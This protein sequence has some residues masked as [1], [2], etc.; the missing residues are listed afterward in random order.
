MTDATYLAGTAGAAG[1]APEVTGLASRG[2][3]L[4]AGAFLLYTFIGTRPFS[5]TSVAG[6]TD[7]NILDRVAVIGMV[8]LALKLLW[9]QRG[10]ALTCLGHNLP[11]FGLVGFAC[12]SITWSDYPD[13]TLRRGMLLAF[14]TV[15]AMA[16]AV[17]VS[18]L[19]RFHTF[20]FV[21]MTGVVLFNL[22]GTV[23]MPSMSIT[24]IGVKG[25]YTQKNV[26]GIV[27]MITAILGVSWIIGADDRKGVIRALVALAPTLLFL[28]LT[29]SKTSINMTVAGIGLLTY[30]ALAEK[31]GRTFILATGMVG[32]LMLAAG[33]ATLAAIEFDGDFVIGQ[34]FGD[35]TLSGRDELWAYCRREAEKRFWLGYG[36][37]AYWDVGHANDPL[38][39][40]EPGTWLASVEI[41]IINQAHHGY[42][43][44]WLH[45]GWPATVAATLIVIH[46]VLSGGM[47]AVAGPGTVA[48]RAALGGFA[49][50]LAVH[51]IHNFT[52]AT[53]FMR[54]S[55]FC[56]TVLIALFLLSRARALQSERAA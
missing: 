21:S 55:L 25:V 32:L 18:D 3:T 5:D 30:F 46:R 43:E 29:R 52:E 40:V 56:S 49:T 38:A 36:Y 11:L 23:A 14:L 13:L 34:I 7:G 26:A 45:I 6:R 4:L 2:H 1:R 8:L 39:R 31:I 10:T 51:L 41:G 17:G 24:D 42:L 48:E 47:A 33:I 37:G 20:L 27:A 19:R 35:S 12:L 53:L 44:L 50:L 22:I 9:D 28:A 54:G 16:I 15:I